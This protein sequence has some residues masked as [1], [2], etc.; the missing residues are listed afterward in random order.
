MKYKITFLALLLIL[1]SCQTTKPN[2]LHEICEA[3]GLFK[4]YDSKELGFTFNVDTGKKKFKR[5]WVWKIQENKIFEDGKDV[6][7]SGKYI[8]DMYWL[9]YP[10][11]AY[12]TQDQIELTVNKD[13]TCPIS[14]QKTCEIVT[15]YITG[16]GKSP[17]D[18]YKIYVD[19]NLKI[20]AWSFHRKSQEKPNL[21]NAWIDYKNVNGLN[22]SMMRTSEGPFKLFFTDVYLK[23]K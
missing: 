10:L 18:T 17:N 12:E 6:G 21:V 23:E 7:K 14:G 3:N 5:S 9:V 13:V 1:C 8:N 16:L 4:I 22:I 15:K 2:I 11:M 20:T 19:K